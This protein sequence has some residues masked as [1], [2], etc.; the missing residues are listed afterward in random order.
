MDTGAEKPLL[1]PLFFFQDEKSF[2]QEQG[3]TSFTPGDSK[4]KANKQESTSEENKMMAGKNETLDADS[5][6][7]CLLLVVLYNDKL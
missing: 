5:P 6:T 3:D 1:Q 7:F 4:A 2:V